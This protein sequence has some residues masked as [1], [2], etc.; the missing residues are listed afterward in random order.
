L[1]D[2][3]WPEVRFESPWIAAREREEARAAIDRL[4]AWHR[5]R[6]ARQLVGSEVE[7]G[8]TVAI[9]SDTVRLTGRVDRLE[10]DEAGAL[11]VADL[12]TGKNPPS[13]AALPEHPQLG[14]YQLAVRHSAFANA[15]GGPC[16]PDSTERISPGGARLVPHCTDEAENG[17]DRRA[18][19]GG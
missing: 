2:G 4:V 15:P 18:S 9:E 3:V 5:S 12:K 8:V 19:P 1:L 11:P 17:G 13:N 16:E 7:F 14:V 6:H 10:P